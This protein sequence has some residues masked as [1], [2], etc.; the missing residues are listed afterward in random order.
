[1][2]YVSYP[3]G[4]A[5]GCTSGQE[6]TRIDFYNERR[7]QVT[8]TRYPFVGTPWF[9]GQYVGISGSLQTPCLSSSLNPERQPD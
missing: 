9:D 6:R 3:A 5:A 2:G 1:M 4:T 7:I 8:S